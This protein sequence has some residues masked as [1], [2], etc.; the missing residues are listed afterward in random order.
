MP[1][2]AFAVF[3]LSCDFAAFLLRVNTLVYV[4]RCLYIEIKQFC[5]IAV[6]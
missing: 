6:I 3:D 2:F 4:L 5:L 1:Q